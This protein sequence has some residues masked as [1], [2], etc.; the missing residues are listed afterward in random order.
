MADGQPNPAM[1]PVPAANP[2][3]A[4]V[5]AP[6]GPDDHKVGADEWK[7]NLAE[8]LTEMEGASDNVSKNANLLQEWMNQI[9]YEGFDPMTTYSVIKRKG[10]AGFTDDVMRMCVILIC[11]G[12]KLGH[13]ITKMSPEGAKPL[14][15]LQ[16]K[17]G[18]V[19][20]AEG[21]GPKTITLGRIG[22][23]WPLYCG[24]ISN[25]LGLLPKIGEDWSVVPMAFGVPQIAACFPRNRNGRELLFMH[26]YVVREF[27]KLIHGAQADTTKARRFQRA[28]FGSKIGSDDA[29]IKWCQALGFLTQGGDLTFSKYD[30]FLALGLGMSGEETTVPTYGEDP[31]TWSENIGK[32]PGEVANSIAAGW[33]A[34]RLRRD[35]TRKAIVAAADDQ[36]DP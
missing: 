20:K 15:E 28:Q 3:A 31:S 2:A 34:A 21:T 24:L 32:T 22:A 19:D 4:P 17:Y 27:E 26:S 1:A 36:G 18:I 7:R 8:F 30:V 9:S 16:K 35:T 6:R 14:I 11:R 29:R 13:V 23:T 12:S 5:Q 33:D 25:E 10:G